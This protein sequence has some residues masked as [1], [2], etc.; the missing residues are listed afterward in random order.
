MKDSTRTTLAPD[1]FAERMLV[2]IPRLVQASWRDDRAI[3]ALRDITL[4]QLWALTHLAEGGGCT[5]CELADRL[6]MSNSTTTGLADQLVARGLVRRQRSREDRRVVN[7][8]LTRRGATMMARLR[9]QKKRML[10]LRF[11]RLTGAERA[12]YLAIVEKV[13]AG[14]SG[15]RPAAR[16]RAGGGR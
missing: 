1:D 12:A 14:S 8:G 4:P 16:G 10:V 2:L 11:G 6:S 15:V 3:L 7:L 9:E 13:V 5:M